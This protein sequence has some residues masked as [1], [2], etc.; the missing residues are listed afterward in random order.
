MLR[1]VTRIGTLLAGTSTLTQSGALVWPKIENIYK[2]CLWLT[3][4]E[5]KSDY[6]TLLDKTGKESMKIRRIKTHV[7]EI[8]KTIN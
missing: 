6:K 7:I 8:F 2:L 1:A 4:N 5:Y 3:L